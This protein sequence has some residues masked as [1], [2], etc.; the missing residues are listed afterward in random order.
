MT[1]PPKGKTRKTYDLP[2]DLA[3]WLE[4]HV[5]QIRANE[6]DNG[7]PPR[8]RTTETSVILGLLT[9]YQRSVEQLS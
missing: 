2:E 6:R 4:K 1:P 8:K 7:T 3:L 5:E 9:K